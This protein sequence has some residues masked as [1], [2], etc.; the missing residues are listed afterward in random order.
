[1]IRTHS[2]E[3]HKDRRLIKVSSDGPSLD[4]YERAT[5]LR[6]VLEALH[7]VNKEVPVIVEGKR[8]ARALRTL[9]L[10]G[11]IIT[12]HRGNNLYEFCEEV[13][14]RYE[15][16][17]ILLDWDEKGEALRKTV[18]KHL[19]GLWEEYSAF[20]EM[21]KILCQKDIKDIEGIPRLLWKLEGHEAIRE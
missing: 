16:V 6:E 19:N 5:K 11:E 4:D 7:E 20:R 8:D 1:M 3:V 10:V 2:R 13:I 9:G 15:Q 18:Q 14:D 17:V 12:L 21:L